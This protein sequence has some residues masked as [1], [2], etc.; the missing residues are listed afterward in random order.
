MDD[1]FKRIQTL[2][3]YLESTGQPGW[4]ARLL[5]ALAGSTGGEVLTALRWHLRKLLEEFSL[6]GE[7]ERE[8]RGLLQEIEAT[9]LASWGSLPD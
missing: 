4:S 1:F 8:A 5:E 7:R 6:S 2:A 9:M 3:R